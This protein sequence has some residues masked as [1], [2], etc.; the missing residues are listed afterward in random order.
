M[1]QEEMYARMAKDNLILKTALQ[2]IAKATICHNL[3]I[4]IYCTVNATVV[5]AKR[6]LAET[7]YMPESTG[8][9]L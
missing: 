3:E 4:G 1:I 6:A 9:H 2:K 7:T 8:E 5:V